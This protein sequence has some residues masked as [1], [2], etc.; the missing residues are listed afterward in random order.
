[1]INSFYSKQKWC[2]HR[3]PMHR[4]NLLI[5]SVRSGKT[6]TANYAF[7]KLFP[8]INKDG[9]IFLI[10][11]TLGS[12]ERN[13]INP[14]RVAIGEDFSF[15]KHKSQAQLWGRIIHCFGANDEQAKD[16][17]QGSTCAFAY[18]DEVTLWP[19]SFFSM[20]D[21]RLSPKGALFV[22]TSNTDSP[23]HYLKADYIDRQDKGVDVKVFN[24]YLHDNSK[25]NGGFL[26]D[27]FI[28]N[29]STNYTGLW[30]KRYIE[31]KWCVA[32]GAIYDFFDDDTHVIS[33]APA[34]PDWYDIT[35]DYGTSN[36]TVFLLVGTTTKTIRPSV[37]AE[38]EYYYNSVKEERQKTDSEYAKDLVYFVAPFTSNIDSIIEYRFGMEELLRLKS[39]RIRDV[40]LVN[41]IIDPSAASFALELQR[42]GFTG[43][44]DADNSVV[45]G[46]RT[47]SRVLKSRQAA[48]CQDCKNLIKEMKSYRWDNKAQLIGIDKPIKKFDHAPDAFR[49]KLHTT[50]GNLNF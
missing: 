39:E 30:Y 12:L 27:S 50:F 3:I 42:W 49:Y 13:V 47:V 37:W 6:V 44:I 21:S 14:L 15:S 35:I 41:I 32:E 46:I 40:P 19:K 36:P 26:E 8:N 9:D 33:H 17:I 11:R 18:G 28:Q 43:I 2:M 48:I 10:G 25:A 38:K 4:L 1:M 29:I 5:G 22:G 23:Y 24:F 34:I 45:D 20:L 31:N 16:A 7:I